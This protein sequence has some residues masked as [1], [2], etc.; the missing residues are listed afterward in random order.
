[1]YPVG[2]PD[3]HICPPFVFPQRP[4]GKSGES[5]PARFYGITMGK[6]SDTL[7]KNVR[8]NCVHKGNGGKALNLAFKLKMQSLNFSAHDQVDD[9][10]ADHDK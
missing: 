6:L 10:N 3:S 9:H 1:M 2:L 7:A 5:I 8:R 4:I